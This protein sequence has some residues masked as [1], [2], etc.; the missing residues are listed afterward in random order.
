LRLPR[1]W[2]ASKSL[3]IRDLKGFRHADM[4]RFASAFVT[5]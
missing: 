3:A 5:A 2:D 4:S 1:S